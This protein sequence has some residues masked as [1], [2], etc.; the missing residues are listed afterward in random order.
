M[1]AA[2]VVDFPS[3]RRRRNFTGSEDCRTCENSAWVVAAVEQ[4]PIQRLEGGKTVVVGHHDEE[5]LGPCP[6]CE[7]GFRLEFGIG[8][9]KDGA[10]YT[11]DNGGPWGR[12]GFWRGRAIPGGLHA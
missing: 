8:K 12:E 1:N 4:R 11:N 9:T 6:H 7:R 3:T 2:T 10:E 5:T